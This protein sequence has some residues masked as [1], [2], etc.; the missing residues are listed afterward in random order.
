MTK[1][2]STK[3]QIL[4]VIGLVCPL[5]VLKAEKAMRRLP[6]DGELVILTNDPL[7]AVDIP[8]MCRARGYDF[9]DATREADTFVFRIRHARAASKG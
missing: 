5:P 6:A 7:A 1:T 8:H 9:V 2:T 4:D 3:T